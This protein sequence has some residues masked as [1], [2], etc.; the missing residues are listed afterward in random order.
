ML[1]LKSCDRD[2]VFH[3]AKNTY[4][5]F[6]TE[7]VYRPLLYCHNITVV[8]LWMEWRRAS[9]QSVLICCMYNCYENFF[10]GKKIKAPYSQ[11]QDS[12]SDLI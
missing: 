7:K 9:H 8:C 3:S 10:S 2:C 4:Y 6:F 12:H 1:L 11:V 5:L